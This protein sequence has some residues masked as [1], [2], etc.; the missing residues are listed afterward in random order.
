MTFKLCPLRLNEPSGGVFLDYELRVIPMCV[1]SPTPGIIINPHA[2]MATLAIKIYKGFEVNAFESL[3]RISLRGNPDF[4]R[5]FRGKLRL[6]GEGV[7]LEIIDGEETLFAAD[8][9]SV[10]GAPLTFGILSI[11]VRATR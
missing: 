7:L 9:A 4:I 2:T 1:P 11:S 10:N 5:I 8:G 6:F 3:H